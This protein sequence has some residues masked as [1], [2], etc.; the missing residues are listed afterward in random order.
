MSEHRL[1][2]LGSGPVA[3]GERID[4]H[5]DFKS[6]FVWPSLFYQDVPVTRLTDSSDAKVPWELSRCHHILSLARAACLFENGRYA[7]EAYRQLRAWIIENPPGV[8]INWTNTMEVAIRAVNWVWILGTLER[9]PRSARRTS[10]AS[11]RL[12]RSTAGTSRL[13]S[14][15]RPTFEAIIIWPTYWAC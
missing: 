1:D 9:W 10:A 2:I 5:R 4:W 12:C 11:S 6:D 7:D 13:T 14:R 3:L 15:D 8:G